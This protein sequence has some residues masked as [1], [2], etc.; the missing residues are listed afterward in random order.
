MHLAGLFIYPVKSLRGCAVGEAAID[1]LGLVGDRRFMVVD[2]SGRFLT[3]RTLPRMARVETALSRDELLLRAEGAG[4]VAVAL[5]G[6]GTAPA[7]TVSI[8]RSHGLVTED[9]GAEP[10]RWLSEIIGAPCHL[11]RIGEKFRRPVLE[12]PRYTTAP[13]GSP[14]IEGRVV[15]PA[16]VFNFADGYPFMLMNE[17]SVTDLNDRLAA[18]GAEPV[19]MNRFRPSVVVAGAAAFAEDH[20]A[21]LRIGQISFRSGGPCGRCVVTTTDQLTGEH[22]EEPL[23]TLALYRRDPAD[24]TNVNLGLNLIHE[25]KSGTLHTGDRVDLLG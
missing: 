11:V 3:Q 16:D 21:R 13:A 23:R 14:L 9:C 15:S 18:R 5:R 22:G 17:A 10:S 6:D 7:R 8:W 2:D 20:W 19:P 24:T 4:S 1:P 25:T 12:K